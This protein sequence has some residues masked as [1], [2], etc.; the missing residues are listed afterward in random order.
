MRKTAHATFMES[1]THLA[2]PIRIRE[3]IR[4]LPDDKLREVLLLILT[5]FPV[6][7]ARPEGRDR[8]EKAGKFIDQWPADI[9][10]VRRFLHKVAEDFHDDAMSFLEIE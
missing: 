3:H 5:T 6:Y 9:E 8:T 2:S 4:Q 10:Q 7:A 1:N